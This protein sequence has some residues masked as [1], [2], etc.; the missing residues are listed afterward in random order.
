MPSDNLWMEFTLDICRTKLHI[1]VI[2][3][4]L[5]LALNFLALNSAQA[6]S[7]FPEL[8]L[9]PQPFTPFAVSSQATA[10]AQAQDDPLGLSRRSLDQ[11]PPAPN[12]STPQNQPK[13]SNDRLFGFLPNYLTVENSGMIPPLTSKQKFTLVAR[14]SFDPVIIPWTAMIAGISQAENSEPAYGQGMV[15]YGKRFGATLA[16]NVDENF[17]VGAVVPSILHQDPR[18]YQLGKGSVRRRVLYGISR[19]FVIRSDAGTSQFNFSEITGSAFSSAIAVT[20]HPKGD[21][22]FANTMS[23][24]WTQ[25]GWDSV[26]NELKEFWPDIRRKLQH[27]KKTD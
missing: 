1:A 2:S 25:I 5:L 18:Y 10:N 15:G 7:L 24:W 6:D 12:G 13:P 16:D 23:V 17:W 4:F 11:S 3:G 21:R 26:S 9:T 27:A 8:S 20:Y 22:T 19:I 14:T